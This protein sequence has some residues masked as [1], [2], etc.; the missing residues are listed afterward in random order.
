M[1]ALSGG[2]NSPFELLPRPKRARRTLN[3]VSC[4][5]CRQAK[6]KVLTNS[7]F[8]ARCGLLTAK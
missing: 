5:F 7:K 1:A 8:L 2:P 6:A 4:T 3:Y